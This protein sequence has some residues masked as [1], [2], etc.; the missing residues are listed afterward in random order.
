MYNPV[1][2]RWL[3]CDPIGYGDPE[4]IYTHEYVAQRLATSGAIQSNTNLYVY[5]D[6]NPV[7]FVDPS[8][9]F[10]EA[11]DPSVLFSKLTDITTPT[12][13]EGCTGLCIQGKDVLVTKCTITKIVINEGSDKL[14]NGMTEG[15]ICSELQKMIAVF[16][17]ARPEGWL[18]SY[19]NDPC[20]C[21]RASAKL[22]PGPQTVILKDFTIVQTGKVK[23]P[24][25]PTIEITCNV[26][27]TGELEVKGGGIALLGCKKKC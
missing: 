15:I 24:F 23:I 27:V 13:A 12:N 19:C 17:K 26:T 22:S 16:N 2:G 3:S 9:L 14:C 11:I 21:D 4:L 20:E 25:G 8:G 5:T 18:K 6:N 7:N 1:V 10:V